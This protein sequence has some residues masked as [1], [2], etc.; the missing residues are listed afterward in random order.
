MQKLLHLLQYLRPL[1]SNLLAVLEQSL[2]YKSL[3]KGQHL[4]REGQALRLIL[5]VESGMLRCY[6]KCRDVI[7]TS[8]FLIDGEVYAVDALEDVSGLSGQSIQALENSEVWYLSHDQLEDIYRQFPEFNLHGRLLMQR[9]VVLAEKVRYMLQ[10]PM[11]AERYQYFRDHFPALVKRTPV[12]DLASYLQMSEF[13]LCRVRQAC[14]LGSGNV[15]G[16]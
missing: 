1:S 7:T 14:K 11:K 3:S 15:A 16:N 8:R 12:S 2:R 10:L 6:H 4:M 5:F 13:T 9:H